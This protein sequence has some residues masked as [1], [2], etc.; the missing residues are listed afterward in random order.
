[1]QKNVLRI[2]EIESMLDTGRGDKAPTRI[3]FLQF[4]DQRLLEEKWPT[5]TVIF[6]WNRRF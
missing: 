6:F 1:M 4:F 2:F 3:N 5:I